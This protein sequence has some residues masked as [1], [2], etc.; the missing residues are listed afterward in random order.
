MASVPLAYLKIQIA[1]SVSN[2]ADGSAVRIEI[3]QDADGL[4]FLCLQRV[5]DKRKAM[6]V[7]A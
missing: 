4:C 7:G 2:M 1:L 3:P 6:I 5:Q